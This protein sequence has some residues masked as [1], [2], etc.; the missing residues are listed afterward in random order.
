MVETPTPLNRER[1]EPLTLTDLGKKIKSEHEALAG[2]LRGIVD[3]AIRIGEDLNKAKDEVGH[4]SFLKWVKLNCAMSNKNAE[5]YMALATGKDKLMRKLQ[6]LS[7]EATDKFD[8][9]SNLSLAQAHRL[10]ED[11]SGGSEGNASDA[12]DNAEKALLKKLGALRSDVAEAAATETIA[13]LQ[14]TIAT[15]KRVA[16]QAA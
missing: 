5:R 16:P 13:R 14:S 8:M 3:R 4:G 7:A 15:M 2:I 1:T 9:L 6:E 12:Y 10:I 11:K